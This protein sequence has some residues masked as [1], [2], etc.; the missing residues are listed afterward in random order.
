MKRISII[1][2]LMVQFMIAPVLHAQ[3][4]EARRA[5]DNYREYSEDSGEM[6]MLKLGKLR[7]IRALR[8]R[9][10]W[11]IAAGD[12][13]WKPLMA[14]IDSLC[15]DG[16]FA[17]I[18]DADIVKGDTVVNDSLLLTAFLRILNISEALRD[19]RWT[20]E[21]NQETWKRCQE[22]VLRYGKM[23]INCPE[24]P[25]RLSVSSRD[26]PL[27][28]VNIYFSHLRLME[29]AEQ[30]SLVD[31]Q[32]KAMCE[33]L[34]VLALRAWTKPYPNVRTD[35]E[36]IPSDRPLWQVAI[37]YRSVGMMDLI[38][39]VWQKEFRAM[40]QATG[41]EGLLQ[42]GF[43]ADGLCWAFG[44]QAWNGQSM[45]KRI[46]KSLE[47]FKI[48][49][50]TPW[51]GMNRDMAA[52][53]VNFFR[54]SSFYYYKGY[55]VPCLGQHTMLYQADRKFI[56]YR[57]LLKTLII[58]W[59][60]AFTK[61]D[62]K[63]LKQLYIE[64]QG[65]NPRMYR[66][67]YYTGTRWFFNNDDLVKKTG[68]C[69]IIVNMASSRCDGSGS[70]E[71]ADAYNHFS[72]DGATFFQ[73]TGTEYRNVFG[74]YGITAFPGVT[75]REG[76]KYIAP[77]NGKQ[78]YC[79]RH[80][81]AAGATSGGMNAAAGFRYEKISVSERGKEMKRSYGTPEEMVLY[82]VKAYKSYFILGDC[83]VALGAGIT[84]KVPGVRRRI[85][86][87]IDQTEWR[88]SVYLY[89][90]NGMDWVIH[91]GGFAYSVFPQYQAD[92]Y[93]VC[94]TRKTRWVIMNPDNRLTDGLPEKVNIFR[95]W[96]DH[97]HNP[98]N[99]TYGYVVYT[100][101]GRPPRDY[102]FEV[103][104]NDTLVQAVKSKDNNLMGAIFYDARA[105][106]SAKGFAVT[107]SSPCA[108]LIEKTGGY[109]VLSVTDARMDGHCRQIDVVWNHRK[110]TLKM[111]QGN[112]CGQP[113]VYRRR[114]SD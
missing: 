83:L 74:A 15:P 99:D 70:E 18:R 100:G 23:E 3:N 61:V 67:P 25:G 112:L 32:L 101:G 5:F 57:E 29:K 66:N 22:A 13:S 51:R 113:V 79:S 58:D 24:L 46:L 81:F 64:A 21:Y 41:N 69:H 17:D 94:E 71:G 103:L 80:N 30:D 33:M 37:M 2:G 1:I 77:A 87:T 50:N 107:V 44:K 39:E 65:Y 16:S 19:N 7:A 11:N 95:M 40:S 36:A 43:T 55:D 93:H 109:L 45:A 26:I 98:V 8:Q 108:L 28:A 48:L 53:L 35:E 111:P 14:E 88:D 73:R 63:E 59:E 9:Y 38:V 62:F 96:I 90:G 84:N 56:D 10:S 105:E 34:K 52:V 89:R 85:R 110:I 31:T 114:L 104:R 92:T 6:T 102:P 27:A 49:R 20:I 68:R 97:G 75:A 91:E 106:L 42:D 47:L 78:G 76:M 60:D 82:G 86:T 72:A 54:G 12:N 4:E